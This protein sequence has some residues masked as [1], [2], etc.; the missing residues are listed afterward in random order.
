L[1]LTKTAKENPK[2]KKGKKGTKRVAPAPGL[3]TKLGGETVA[4]AVFTLQY[5]FRFKV[6]DLGCLHSKSFS[7]KQNSVVCIRSR[8][9]AFD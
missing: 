1:K 7:K 5:V 3:S 2:S 8:L 6:I 9:Y 4:K